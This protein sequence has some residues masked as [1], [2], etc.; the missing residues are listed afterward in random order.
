MF[1][2]LN[3]IHSRMQ[4]FVSG[5]RC[6]VVWNAT[7]HKYA[8]TGY[9]CPPVSSRS[10]CVKHWIYNPKCC[11]F[12]CA[13]AKVVPITR[14]V[15]SRTRFVLTFQRN[16]LPHRGRE[17]GTLCK[18]CWGTVL[19]AGRSRVRLSMVLLEFFIDLILPTGLVFLGSTQPV[20]EMSTRC[21]LC[22][23]KTAST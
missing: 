7:T 21:L 14:F 8:G 4:R 2:S 23:V 19:Q 17:R 1:S 5:M 15:L 12:C 3:N 13:I 18:F 22:G 10:L 20:T 9:V 6:H 16:V 11:T